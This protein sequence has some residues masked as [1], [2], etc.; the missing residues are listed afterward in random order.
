MNRVLTLQLLLGLLGTSVA[1]ANPA[2]ISETQAVQEPVTEGQST[3]AASTAAAASN[4]K[5]HQAAGLIFET[6]MNFSEVQT[7]KNDTVG[8]V[9]ADQRITIKLFP[10]G[11]ETLSFLNMEDTELM[12]Y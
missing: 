4:N 9:S 7:L 8:V 12:N 6:P 3:P 10:L 1:I 5:H 11:P 2:P